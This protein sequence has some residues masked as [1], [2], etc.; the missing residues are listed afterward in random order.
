MG[1]TAIPVR[2]YRSVREPFVI[3]RRNKRAF[4]G[5]IIL[6]IFAL[7]ATVGPEVVPLDTTQS[8]EKRFQWPSLEHPLGTDHVG[9]DTF[10][11]IVHGSRDVLITAFLAAIFATGV[12]ILIG[13]LAGLQGGMMDA[14]LML[15]TNAI[16]TVPSLP[17]LMIVASVWKVKDPVRLGLLLSIW[18]WGGLARAIRSQVLSLREREFIEAARALGLGTFHTVFRELLPNVMPYVAINF[19]TIMRGAITASVGLMFLG[20][21]PFKAT[22]WGMM[23]SLA[24]WQ[25]GAIYVPKALFY[26]GSP[27]ACIILFQL[28]AF[29]FANGLD[30]V[31]DPR[32]RVV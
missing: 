11:Q 1:V 16:L 6:I 8:F 28:G 20:L 12:A 21:I 30:E 31:L 13:M 4:I 23:L 29:F 25:T 9:R 26:F 22:N 7:M 10:Q 18:A 32:L 19:F 5:L 14:V 3:I 2:L 24:A 17:V 27:M 15:M